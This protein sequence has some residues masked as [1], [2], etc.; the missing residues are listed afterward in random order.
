LSPRQLCGHPLSLGGYL[1]GLDI[2]QQF[3]AETTFINAPIPACDY[4]VRQ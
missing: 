2:R 1:D 3:N 4:D